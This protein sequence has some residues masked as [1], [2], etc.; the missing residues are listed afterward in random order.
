MDYFKISES[1]RRPLALAWLGPANAAGVDLYIG[2]EEGQTTEYGRGPRFVK[3]RIDTDFLELLIRRH[4]LCQSENVNEMTGHMDG[5]LIDSGRLTDYTIWGWAL[6]VSEHDFTIIGNSGMSL[7]MSANAI[8]TE[9]LAEVL[10]GTSESHRDL[11][12][13]SALANADIGSNFRW[14]GG[15]LFH[16]VGSSATNSV[17]DFIELVTE[18]VPELAAKEASIQLE[19]A[20]AER[21]A[22]GAAG[23]MAPELEWVNSDAGGSALHD[24]GAAR[25]RRRAGMF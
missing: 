2:T 7:T 14:H 8:N 12:S 1:D 19:L 21:L 13:E 6:R 11:K 17:G 16:A 23:G 9:I 20:M 4:G 3:I 24:V 25:S 22:A 18:Q 15:A 5:A 10:A